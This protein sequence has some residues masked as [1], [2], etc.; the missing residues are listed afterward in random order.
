MVEQFHHNTELEIQEVHTEILN[1]QTEAENMQQNHNTEVKVFLQKL[2]LLE[3]EQQK[4]DM[5]IQK[6][7][8]DAK[9]KENNYYQNRM[10]D[11][12]KKKQ[13]LKKNIIEEEKVHIE[14]TALAEH[15][16]KR[17]E[18]FT[19]AQQENQLSEM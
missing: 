9:I 14:K 3:Y 6:D 18:E 1:K 15:D 8:E 2:K 13:D 5:N 4:A 19:V 16:H 12:K 17:S 7:G 11:M 10:K